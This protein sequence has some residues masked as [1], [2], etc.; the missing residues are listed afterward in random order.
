[1]IARL[2]SLLENFEGR[3]VGVLGDMVADVYIYGRPQRL[4]REAPVI[5]VRYE[6]EETIP[7]GAANTVRNLLSL[8]ARAI[9]VSLLGNDAA[10]HGIRQYFSERGVDT[11]GVLLHEGF[12]S[13][14]KT[15]I[16]AGDQNRTKQ[17]VIRI[18]RE[19]FSRIPAEADARLLEVFA[20]I[21]R[22]VEAWIISDYNYFVV[23]DSIIARL[24]E[25][26]KKKQVVADSRH[27]LLSF[28]GVTL[29]TPNEEEAC[30]AVGC[31]LSSEEE[32]R[33]VGIKL[34]KEL[35]GT[36]A[37]ITRGNN[38]MILFESERQISHIPVMGGEQVVD[39][40]GAGD[41]VT[42]VAGLALVSG[43][44]LREAAELANMA[45]GIVVMKTGAATC[46]RQEMFD[47]LP[48]LLKRLEMG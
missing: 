28:K 29:V 39:V 16:M 6:H 15:R 11:R 13:V 24:R 47:R 10:G 42:A 19:P 8:G 36:R 26:S 40:T 22:E 20:A 44:T 38:G 35:G 21:D 9:P 45:A 1:M 48:F 7:G 25:L 5:V 27:R 12:A 46:T 34:L 18:D 3:R 17:Q 2:K 32:I 43:A 4:S 37:L 33:K 41:T 23:G 14:T 31:E 30:E